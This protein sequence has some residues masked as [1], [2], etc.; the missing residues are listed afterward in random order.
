MALLTETRKSSH[1][2]FS[3]CRCSYASATVRYFPRLCTS[4]SALAGSEADSTLP[5]P[6]AGNDSGT[7]NG[8]SENPG[9]FYQGHAQDPSTSVA[10]ND[11]DFVGCVYAVTREDPSATV[12]DAVQEVMVF[13]SLA[14]EPGVVDPNRTPVSSRSSGGGNRDVEG[15]GSAKGG[16]STCERGGN[17]VTYRVYLTDQSG[18]RVCLEKQI[19][20]EL[21]QHHRIL[22]SSPGSCWAVLNASVRVCGST[23]KH[24]L[25]KIGGQDSRESAKHDTSSASA[26][27]RMGGHPLPTTLGD[28][29][30]IFADTTRQGTVAQVVTLSWSSLSAVGGSGGAPPPATFAGTTSG[31]IS[32][33]FLELRKWADGKEGRLAVRHG[34]QHL[35]LQLTRSRNTVTSKLGMHP[36]ANVSTGVIGFIS[37]FAVVCSSPS[38]S[39]REETSHA[40]AHENWHSENTHN[41]LTEG[42]ERRRQGNSRDTL[43]VWVDTGENLFPLQVLTRHTFAQLLREALPS[44]S[45]ARV[46]SC[47]ARCSTFRSGPE[48]DGESRLETPATDDGV[49]CVLMDH[50]QEKKAEISVHP[51]VAVSRSATIAANISRLT[52]AFVGNEDAPIVQSIRQ[53]SGRYGASLGWADP[54]ER[55]YGA[56]EACCPTTSDNF[57]ASGEKESPGDGALVG[58]SR[59]SERNPMGEVWGECDGATTN[60]EA[61]T[62]CTSGDCIG[63]TKAG[64]SIVEA[65]ADAVFCLLTQRRRQEGMDIDGVAERDLP[66]TLIH[67]RGDATVDKGDMGDANIVS[68]R[69][70][71]LA[72]SC[73]NGSALGAFVA[74]SRRS[75]NSV[76]DALELLAAVCRGRRIALTTRYRSCRQ[77]LRVHGARYIE[78]V[79]SVDTTQVAGELLADLR[80][81]QP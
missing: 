19:H 63:G 53:V 5:R 44:R 42:G 7:S 77:A 50:M 74:S 43:W 16:T 73:G 8:N 13:P 61:R 1:S 29:A 58:Q 28:D 71:S 55:F 51:G 79:G 38:S 78:S 47:A 70:S 33:P 64:Q 18:T 14:T 24:F 72:C 36:D 76:A 32:Q 10:G 2:P 35:A 21:V 80:F 81:C 4:L 46:S 31:H 62:K 49:G 23:K 66:A 22:R 56:G 48:R 57:H 67:R 27:D 17:L 9:V 45:Q 39:R 34:G 75:Q 20:Q 11:V 12:T 37:S 40:S 65:L 6:T 15:C 25:P 52:R 30:V 26:I 60:E 54:D 3:V 41:V 68:G 69:S 59:S